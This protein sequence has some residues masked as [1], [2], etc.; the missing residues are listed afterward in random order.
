MTLAQLWALLLQLV[1]ITQTV[2]AL[3]YG[4]DRAVKGWES[5]WQALVAPITNT[6]AIVNNVTYGNVAL[7][8]ALDSLTGSGTY[9]LN[10]ILAAIAALPA[11]SALPALGDITGGVW[12]VEDP[13]SDDPHIPYGEELTNSHRWATFMIKGGSVPARFSP[14]FNVA[15]PPPAPDSIPTNYTWPQP[16]W[17]DIRRTDALVIWLERTC[18]DF[19]WTY[20]ASGENIR[21]YLT[22]L[23]EAEAPHYTPR[24]TSTEWYRL[25]VAPIAGPPIWPGQAGVTDGEPTVLTETA[26][27]AGPMDGIKLTV[28]SGPGGAG[29]WGVD[30]FRSYY[31]AGYVVFLDAD[32]HADTTQF[33]G[34]DDNIFAP[35]GMTTAASVVVGLNKATQITVTPW[36]LGAPPP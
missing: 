1:G 17:G 34:P 28:D 6:Y 12:G 22:S 32:G 13:Y 5:E 14:F 29:Q 21:G 9:D 24:M 23:Y 19:T 30:D 25:V 15:Y 7:K 18:P 27:V 35:K 4:L 10:A 2:E 11:G 33:I 20:D 3:L 16:D 8:S 26:I 31:R 36:T